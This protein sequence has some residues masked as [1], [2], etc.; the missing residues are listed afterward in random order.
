MAKTTPI[1]VALGAEYQKIALLK[2]T[3]LD[4]LR[5]KLAQEMLNSVIGKSGDNFKKS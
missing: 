4:K 3:K 1:Q 5:W 2:P